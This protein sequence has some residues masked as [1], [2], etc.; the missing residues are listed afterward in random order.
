M[1]RRWFD[2]LP[3]LLLLLALMFPLRGGFTDDGFIHVQYARNIMTRGEYSFNPGETSFGTTSPLWVMALAVI[4][5]PF[6]DGQALVVAGKTLSWLA[7]F[8]AVV[9]F[10]HLLVLLG[11]T[12]R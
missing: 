5:R 8:A 4:A 1:N 3:A 2:T 6:S 9:V 7:A 12:R 11:A 10:H